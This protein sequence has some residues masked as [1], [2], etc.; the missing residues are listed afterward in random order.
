MGSAAEQAALVAEFAHPVSRDAE[1]GRVDVLDL[2]CGTGR[3]VGA[4]AVALPTVRCTGVDW[5]PQLIEYAEHEYPEAV[6]HVADLRSVHLHR[7]YDIIVCLGDAL[8]HLSPE[9]IDIDRACSVFAEHARPGA[10][11]LI[12][13]RTHAAPV[14]EERR[15]LAPKPGLLD[16]PVQLRTSVDVD[17][18][19]RLTLHR[20]WAFAHGPTVRDQLNLWAHD[21]D[22]LS[23]RLAEVGFHRRD[24]PAPVMAFTFDG[25]SV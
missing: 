23:Q 3:L 9:G 22:F 10:T 11:L 6:Y 13:T 19:Q 18:Q 2:G 16:G 5:Q 15:I 20:V 12:G 25:Q 14:P 17:S 21:P 4:L 1:R 8:A 24:G 7:S